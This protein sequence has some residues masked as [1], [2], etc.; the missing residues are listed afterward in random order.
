LLSVSIDGVDAKAL[1]DAM[2]KFKSKLEPAV[3]VLGTVNDGKVS[4]VA[5]V[6]KSLTGH[7]KAGDLVNMLAQQVGGKGGGRPDMAMAGGNDPAGLQKALASVQGYVENLLK[8][9]EG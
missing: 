1:R 4:L 2:D 5:G 7:I 9:R 3:I 6:S 8:T